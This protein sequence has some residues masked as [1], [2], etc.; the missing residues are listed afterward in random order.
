MKIA[1]VIPTGDMV[2]T[3]FAMCLNNLILTHNHITPDVEIGVFN[4][5]CSLVPKG[6]WLGVRQALDMNADKILFIDSDQTFPIDGLARLIHRDKAI[7]GATSL[8]RREPFEY[9]A[10]NEKGDRI[11]FSKK[12]GL[13]K[14]ASNGFP[15]CL[16]DKG[17]FRS[18]PEASWFKI[19]QSTNKQWMSEDENFC[20]KAREKCYNIWVDADLTKEIGHLGVKEYK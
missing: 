5:R 6:R 14:V 19:C 9:T 8:T 16:I 3:D 18:I 4:P 11:D 7:V 2:H 12:E 15:F 1:I 13:V 10:R 17:V 20:K